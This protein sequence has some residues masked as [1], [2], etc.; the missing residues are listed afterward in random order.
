MA[1]PNH[2]EAVFKTTSED[3]DA[4][5]DADTPLEEE[6]TKHYDLCKLDHAISLTVTGVISLISVTIFLLGR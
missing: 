3:K 4:A 6:K 1:T 2:G 5:F